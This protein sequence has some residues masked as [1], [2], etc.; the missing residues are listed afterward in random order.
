MNC[1]N[2][3]LFPVTFQ[4]RQN[5]M[6]NIYDISP[7]WVSDRNVFCNISNQSKSLDW[8]WKYAW[9]HLPR[10]RYT[11]HLSRKNS[12]Y[13]NDL[14]IGIN[15]VR[16]ASFNVPLPVVVPKTNGY[17]LPSVTNPMGPCLTKFE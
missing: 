14:I 7:D 2:D 13:N 15:D 10:Q 9:D 12:G 1:V 3:I 8:S 4:N 5:L 16:K 11:Q 17:R 6:S